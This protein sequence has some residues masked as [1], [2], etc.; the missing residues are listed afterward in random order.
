MNSQTNRQLTLNGG[1]SL[2]TLVEQKLNSAMQGIEKLE[3]GDLYNLV[4][5]QVERPLI[6]CVLENTGGNQ[7]RAADILGLNRNTLR[8]KIRELEIELPQKT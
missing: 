6:R 4:L 3:Q 7:L 8:K 5:A 2:E 1:L